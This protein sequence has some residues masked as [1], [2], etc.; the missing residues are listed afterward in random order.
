MEFRRGEDDIDFLSGVRAI[1]TTRFLCTLVAENSTADFPRGRSSILGDLGI[2]KVRIWDVHSPE[3]LPL[4]SAS[5][6]GEEN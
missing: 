3:C 1:S 2:R 4:S 6:P 5:I